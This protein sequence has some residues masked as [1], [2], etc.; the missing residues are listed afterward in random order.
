MER[1]GELVVRFFF[2]FF[3]ASFF[4]ANTKPTILLQTC[5]PPLFFFLLLEARVSL[6]LPL[7]SWTLYRRCSRCNVTRFPRSFLCSATKSFCVAL[8]HYG[9]L[10]AN[11]SQTL[12]RI[13]VRARDVSC[14]TISYL[15][16]C[17]KRSIARE[18]RKDY[19]F[20]GF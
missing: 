16:F 3:S 17:R 19:C 14:P 1:E 20:Q 7:R 4:F 13:F 12:R 18:F 10:P 6:F 9:T 11:P 2:S 5:F 8:A 15:C